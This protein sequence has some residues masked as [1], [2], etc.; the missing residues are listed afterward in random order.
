VPG[1]HGFSFSKKEEDICYMREKRGWKSN[2]E[3]YKID[4]SSKI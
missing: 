2:M 1:H 3:R 4:E